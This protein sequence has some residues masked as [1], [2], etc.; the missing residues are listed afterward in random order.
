MA[1]AFNADFAD[2]FLG[3]GDDHPDFGDTETAY[4]SSVL[5][6]GCT[7][8]LGGTNTYMALR[9]PNCEVIG[10]TIYGTAGGELTSDRR[11]KAVYHLRKN[12][13]SI[14]TLND[15]C[16]H[17]SPTS[18]PNMLLL[19]ESVI[20]DADLTIIKNKTG[21]WIAS[22]SS[23]PQDHPDSMPI[24][25][26]PN[27][28]YQLRVDNMPDASEMKKKN[29]GDQ[30]FQANTTDCGDT[31][32]MS[33][34]TDDNSISVKEAPLVS[35]T[36]ITTSAYS[37]SNKDLA[38]LG[39]E[40]TVKLMQGRLGFPNPTLLANIVEHTTGLGITPSDATKHARRI[41]IRA[42]AFQR[43]RPARSTS[44]N[45]HPRPY[46]AHEAA[47]CRHTNSTKTTR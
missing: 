42:M 29:K 12:N 3:A 21:C 25:R 11:S 27:G 18:D 16:L 19:S 43:R 13:G 5:D 44:Q 39:K 20:T 47:S 31:P 24:R 34:V 8:S 28:L 30:S 23:H 46:K 36:D 45:K 1:H 41:Q 14:F 17:H 33:P 4:L 38:H 2:E 7:K 35:L 26:S 9:D 10:D 32:A 40:E 22:C 37:A 15:S 6:G